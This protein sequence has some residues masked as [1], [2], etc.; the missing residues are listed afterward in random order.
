[1]SEILDRIDYSIIVPTRGDR[2]HLRHALASALAG[3]ERLEVLLI[4]DRRRGE[5]SLPRD[6]ASD[7]CVRTFESPRP[8]LPAARNTGLDAAAGRYAAFLD[9]DD[10]F[11]P[12]HLARAGECLR[13]QPELTLFACQALLFR[14]ITPDG[15]MPPPSDPEGLPPLWPDGRA[16]ALGRGRLLLGNPIAADSVVL[17]LDKLGR[18]RRFDESLPSL[19]DHE[20]W[21]RLARNGH[22]LWFDE[23]PGVLVRKR[24]GSMSRDRRRMAQCALEV[25]RREIEH[26]VPS[27]E[28]GPAG[29]RAREGRLWH[30]LAYACLAEDD[31]R[32]ARHAL[33]RSIPRLPFLA[34]NYA[35]LAFSTLPGRFRTRLWSHPVPHGARVES[36]SQP[37]AWRKGSF[38]DGERHE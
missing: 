20:M 24:E 21:L 34:K 16:G 28:V 37:V 32:A 2:P 13:R 29:L 19:E 5:P 35:Y 8:G 11:L 10:L 17:S 4:H 25:L 1:V 22:R 27:G 38:H 30:D 6:L 12:D 36:V 14:D 33:Y 9:D 3:N 7:S 31:P 18:E 26:G 23:R 15:S